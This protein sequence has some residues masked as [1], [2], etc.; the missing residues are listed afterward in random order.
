MKSKLSVTIL[1]V[2]ILTFNGC[3]SINDNS[4]DKGN[5]SEGSL[6]LNLTYSAG[7]KTTVAPV[8]MTPYSYDITGTGTFSL[9]DVTQT[10]VAVN[11]LAAGA[12][13][14]D[15]TAKNADG[16]DIASGSTAIA[17]DAT[18]TAQAN[19]TVKPQ[20]KNTGSFILN[21]SWPDHTINIPTL[22]GVLTSKS[23]EQMPLDITMGTLS[24]SYANSSL[25]AGYYTL[26]M[27][28]HDGGHLVWGRIEGIRIVANHTTNGSIILT[29][30]DITPANEGNVHISVVTDMENPIDVTISGQ[31]QN[32]VRGTNMTVTTATSETVDS[33]LWYLNG[34]PI[35]GETSSSIT[36]GSALAI[37]NYRLDLVVFKG[38][39][40][41]SSGFGFS[42][43]EGSPGMAQ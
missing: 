17:I 23:G 10:A 33:Y 5:K 43:V 3:F 27:K 6:I 20:K 32:I 22:T 40:M 11:S 1:A 21:V 28:I 9:T 8:D 37:A 39:I 26:S 25:S 35:V 16:T 12:W 38:N 2:L 15:V 24:A 7:T 30:N 29:A 19:I 36:I 13:A 34:D 4:G 41:S 31:L 42:V 18:K 14:I